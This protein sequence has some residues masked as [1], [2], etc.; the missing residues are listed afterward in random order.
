MSIRV[1][2]EQHKDEKV[3]FD[4]II[5]IIEKNRDRVRTTGNMIL[6]ISGITLSATLGLLLFLSDKGGITQRSMMTLGILFGSAIS[7]NL[8]SI[9]FSITSSF[10]K[11]KYALTT[12]LKALTDLLKLFYSELRLVRISFIL[13]IIDLLVITIGVF[14]FIY[15]KWI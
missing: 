7:I 3:E 11:E 12:K 1:I 13:L 8:I 6:T 4:T 10:L 2:K 15:V 14:F 9:F 5:Q